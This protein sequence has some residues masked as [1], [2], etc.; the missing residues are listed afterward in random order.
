MI[1]VFFDSG[2]KG[3][4]V[5]IMQD[6]MLGLTCSDTAV[7]LKSI[8]FSSDELD[9]LKIIT[10]AGLIIDLENK[11]TVIDVFFASDDIVKAKAMLVG[12]PKRSCLFGHIN[13]KHFAIVVDT[14]GSMSTTFRFHGSDYSRLSYVKKE[15]VD[16]VEKSLSTDQYFDVIRFSSSYTMWNQS[17]KQATAGNVQSAGNFISALSPYGGTNFYDTLYNVMKI[18]NLEAVYFLSEAV[19]LKYGFKDVQGSWYS[20][21]HCRFPSR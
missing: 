4:A 2:E 21:P 14:S 9:A 20:C 7:L 1:T 19:Y 18:Q 11:Q 8:G 17:L 13:R 16:I 5:N 15:L 12:Q 6:Y 3:K 10:D